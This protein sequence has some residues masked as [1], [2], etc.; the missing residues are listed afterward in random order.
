MGQMIWT[1]ARFGMVVLRTKM[2][3]LNYSYKDCLKL[4]VNTNM[5]F[6]LLEIYGHKINSWFEMYRRVN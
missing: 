2:Q 1:E 4:V 5:Y 6:S 3:I